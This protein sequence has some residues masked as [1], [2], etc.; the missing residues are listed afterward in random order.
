MSKKVWN[1]FNNFKESSNSKFT[2]AGKYDENI[3]FYKVAEIFK[4]FHESFA[5]NSVKTFSNDPL[6]ASKHS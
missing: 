5:V 6:D 3:F 1:I 2:K 4:L